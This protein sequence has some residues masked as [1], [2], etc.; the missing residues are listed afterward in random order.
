M[1]LIRETKDAVAG[2]DVG[3]TASAAERG[4]AK[5]TALHREVMAHMPQAAVQEIRVL[6]ARLEPGDVTPRHSHRHPVTVVM[7]RGTFT[8]NLDGRAPVAIRAG[9]VFVEPAQVL[10]T[11]RNLDP[12]EPAVMT[13]FYVCNPDEPFADPV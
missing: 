7:T 5:L 9:E 13:L 8:L 3:V 11:G 10:M 1:T 2:L 12:Q 4:M 6:H